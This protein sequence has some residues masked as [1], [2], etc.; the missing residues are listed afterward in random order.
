MFQGESTGGPTSQVV[1]DAAARRERE[2]QPKPKGLKGSKIVKDGISRRKALNQKGGDEVVGVELQRVDSLTQLKIYLGRGLLTFRQVQNVP[3]GWILATEVGLGLA[4]SEETAA[5]LVEAQQAL[6]ELNFNL[7]NWWRTGLLADERV[8]RVLESTGFDQF[9]NFYG[10]QEQVWAMQIPAAVELGLFSSAW[11]NSLPI[12]DHDWQ[13]GGRGPI[14]HRASDFMI[15]EASLDPAASAMNEERLQKSAEYSKRR[16][17]IPGV[18]KLDRPLDIVA[19]EAND[20]VMQDADGTPAPPSPAPSTIVELPLFDYIDGVPNEKLLSEMVM[21]VMRY[22]ANAFFEE[23]GKTQEEKLEEFLHQLKQTSDFEQFYVVLARRDLY[24][25]R[26]EIANQRAPSIGQLVD[27]IRELVVKRGPPEGGWPEPAPLDFD[28]PPPS[29]LSVAEVQQ[30]VAT[31]EASS[32]RPTPSEYHAIVDFMHTALGKRALDSLQNANSMSFE[33]MVKTWLPT[34]EM[35]EDLFMVRIPRAF[36]PGSLADKF[37]SDNFNPV[38]NPALILGEEYGNESI[39]WVNDVFIQTAAANGDHTYSVAADNEESFGLFGP[40]QMAHLYKHLFAKAKPLFSVQEGA[41]VQFFPSSF[42]CSNVW[43]WES[44]LEK[45]P[46]GTHW[47]S[48]GQGSFNN[49]YKLE[50][51]GLGSG[52]SALSFLPPPIAAYGLAGTWKQHLP[53][54]ANHGLIKRIAYMP[55]DDQAF[56]EG[57]IRE[58]YLSGYAASC[59]CGPHI[60][61]AYIVPGGREPGFVPTIEMNPGD[62]EERFSNPLYQ[63]LYATNT[64]PSWNSEHAPPEGWFYKDDKWTDIVDDYNNGHLPRIHRLTSQLNKTNSDYNVTKMNPSAPVSDPRKRA[65]KKMVVVMESYQGDMAKFGNHLDDDVCQKAVDALM[66]TFRKLGDAGILHCDIK[67]PNMVYRTWNS[68]GGGSWTDI[69][70]MAIDFDPMYAKLVPWLPAPVIALINAACYF[71]WDAC[72]HKSRFGVH[73]RAPME[74]LRKEVMDNYP[75]GVSEVFRSIKLKGDPRFETDDSDPRWL[76]IMLNNEAEAERTLLHWIGNYLASGRCHRWS[77]FVDMAP[78]NSS[79]LARIVAMAYYSDPSKALEPDDPRK[80]GN[81]KTLQVHTDTATSMRMVAE[82]RMNMWGGLVFS[83]TGGF[84]GGG[85][86]ESSDQSS[87][88][89][90]D[91]SDED[92]GGESGESSSV[93]SRVAKV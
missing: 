85:G 91:E 86:Q 43:W 54:M 82:A 32:A 72:F 35:R 26:D 23:Q 4:I 8:Q 79:A 58:L 66:K 10:S 31:K 92:S 22:A 49:A 53:S 62:P 12:V 40:K 27:Q 1:L 34:K 48:V 24:E 65:W 78:V 9:V 70:T 36:K 68:G 46:V 11:T 5:K 64:L 93:E 87:D 41:A 39:L 57:C 81:F 17:Q 42:V 76:T 25:M 50:I 88:Q 74:A 69:E 21:F 47:R 71:A 59:G 45:M 51:A 52:E 75:G 61:A 55:G 6:P 2:R 18:V 15:D 38:A 29:G 13:Q 14:R 7:P 67:A 28:T 20:T 37:F 83:K 19:P 30:A 90:S 16:A 3:P 44:K 73:I 60:L 77:A 63:P 56:V 33:T 89:S 84:S 80:A